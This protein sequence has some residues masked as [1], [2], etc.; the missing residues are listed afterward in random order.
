MARSNF[1]QLWDAAVRV[2]AGNNASIDKPLVEVNKSESK[3]KY[4]IK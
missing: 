2:L 1:H 4:S 3:D